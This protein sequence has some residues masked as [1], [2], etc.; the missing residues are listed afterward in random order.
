VRSFPRQRI[1][2]VVFD[3]D[4]TLIKSKIGEKK[5][6]IIAARLISKQLKK[7]GQNYGYRVLLEKLKVL[8]REM[9]GW[10]QRY[11]RDLWWK[12]LVRDLHLKRL[13]T[14]FVHKTTRRYWD[15]YANASPPFSDAESTIRK[16]KKMGYK[17]GMVSDSDGTLGM[18]LYRFKK[19]PLHRLF[20]TIV[21]AGED[22]P[23]VKPGHEAFRLVAKLSLIHI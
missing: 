11:N 13:D 4:N 19:L 21:V 15:A 9:L 20:D 14:G 12:T 3:L 1:L 16:L 10:K 17:L 2:A 8:N 22:T 23:R 5:G 6:L 18:K 7:R